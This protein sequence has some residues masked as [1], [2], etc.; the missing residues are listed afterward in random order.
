MKFTSLKFI[1]SSTLIVFFL[2]ISAIPASALNR[3]IK[4]KVTDNEDK[5]IAGAKVSIEGVDIYRVSS[6]KTNKNGEFY[7]I[8]GIQVAT[9]RVVVRVPG[10]KPDAKQ[11]IRPE[12]GE[13]S[14]V[15]F[16]LEPGPDRKFPWE[17]TKEEAAQD[18]EQ[19][20]KLSETQQKRKQFSA[21]VKAHFE[22]GVK[23]YDTGQFNES[24]AEFN[25]ALEKDP[26]QPGI[27]ARTGDCY[28][29]LNKL[30]EALAAYDKAIVMSPNDTSFY[31][32]KGVV[33]SKM[34]KQAESQE[35]F[36]KA[37]ELNPQ[38]AAQNFYNLGV[39]Q[40]NVGDMDN[41]ADSFKR[42]IAA[43]PNYSE[44]YYM[45]GMCLS[46]KTESIPA[47]LE[48]LN[49]YIT[50]GQKPENVEVAKEIIKSL[51]K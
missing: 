48:A 21:E 15:N 47:A 34:G 20:K 43:D 49:K 39:T 1:K 50:I 31:T 24:L 4:G 2:L 35:M 36:K 29:K 22:Q 7:F 18:R 3:A 17:M 25:L 32:S 12:L 28:S 13:E 8:L 6:T 16:K 41:A 5:P 33:L 42:T 46:G 9:Y 23:L 40:Y 37:A 45:L 44:A 51:S 38:A 27:I 26:Q 11:N 10:F 30:E 19:N 14:E